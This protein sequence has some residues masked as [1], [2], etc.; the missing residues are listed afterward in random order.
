MAMLQ[1]S[2]AKYCFFG[3]N[4]TH[5]Y[6]YCRGV[7]YIYI[8]ES[9]YMMVWRYDGTYSWIYWRTK[10]TDIEDFFLPTQKVYTVE[11]VSL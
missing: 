9:V 10:E 2:H 7:I 11:F 6:L 8:L 1:T 5:P 4:I 3:N